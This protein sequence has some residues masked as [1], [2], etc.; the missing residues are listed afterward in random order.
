DLAALKSRQVDGLFGAGPNTLHGLKEIDHAQMYQVVTAETA[1]VRG[2]VSAK[3]FQD[4]RI[5]KALRL[6]VD[7]EKILKISVGSLGLPGEHHHVCPVHR[8]YAKLPPMRRDVAQARG[9][10]AD[11]GYPNGL[12][13]EIACASDVPWQIIGVE[14]MVHQWEE[15]GIRVKINSM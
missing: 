1:V 6:A 8:E 9:L 4:S 14:A 3:P 10:L 2:K 15:A 11:A 7:S 12:D 5:R 13:L